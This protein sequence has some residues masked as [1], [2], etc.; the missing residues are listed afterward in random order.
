[1]SEE[2]TL[3]KAVLHTGTMT[4][5]RI[6]TEAPELADADIWAVEKLYSIMDGQTAFVM[7][8]FITAGEYILIGLTDWEQDKEVHYLIEQDPET[9]CYIDQRQEFDH[10]YDNGE[11]CPDG[12]FCLKGEHVEIIK[13]EVEIIKGENENADSTV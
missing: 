2:L 5:E 10:D 3:F 13:G 6:K 1:M 7:P 11:Y 4:A 8:S 9:G 12:C